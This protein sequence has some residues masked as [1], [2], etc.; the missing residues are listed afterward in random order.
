MDPVDMDGVVVNVPVD[1]GLVD[2]GDP[3]DVGD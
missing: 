3:G 2:P 1:D